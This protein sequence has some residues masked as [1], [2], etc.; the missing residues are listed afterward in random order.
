MSHAFEPQERNLTTLKLAVEKVQ[1][2]HSQLKG[3]LRAL[4]AAI[5]D[6]EP[7][8]R[9]SKH[10]VLSADQIR[11]CIQEL[12]RF[13]PSSYFLHDPRSPIFQHIW[14]P[15][16]TSI[17][18]LTKKVFEHP[19]PKAE[20]KRLDGRFQAIARFMSDWHRWTEMDTMEEAKK[21]K[22]EIL[23]LL[24]K[25][26]HGETRHNFVC[27]AQRYAVL[28]DLADVKLHMYSTGHI[29]QLL[30]EE[31]DALRRRLDLPPEEQLSSGFQA[32]EFSVQ[33]VDPRRR[34]GGI[35][36]LTR[37]AFALVLIDFSV[38]EEFIPN[39]NLYLCRHIYKYLWT[40]SE[41][42]FK[43]EVEDAHGRRPFDIFELF[44]WQGVLDES[45][46]MQALKSCTEVKDC[47][48]GVLSSARYRER[49][50]NDDEFEAVVSDMKRLKQAALDRQHQSKQ[51]QDERLQRLLAEHRTKHSHLL[52][53]RCLG[54]DP[55]AYPTSSDP[56]KLVSM[57]KSPIDILKALYFPLPVVD[58]GRAK[59]VIS[60]LY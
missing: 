51:E 16:P 5:T 23:I 28:S 48:M 17:K 6:F 40:N 3:D 7:K 26:C 20:Y 34:K 18:F 14:S 44:T 11:E 52:A 30:K 45:W 36:P 54:G 21:L 13:S 38:F 1:R 33:A 15:S 41:A 4:A 10:L 50:L 56:L 37:E 39:T 24:E 8:T 19:N 42:A 12:E 31:V 46:L 47:I 53:R 35:R 58:S 9:L 55:S 32:L 22:V 60:S 57:R 29:D 59:A 43:F 27:A 49:A 25:A 2:A